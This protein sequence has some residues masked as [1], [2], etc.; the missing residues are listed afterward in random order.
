MGLLSWVFW[1][2]KVAQTTLEV[3]LLALLDSLN[4][5]LDRLIQQASKGLEALNVLANDIELV[6]ALLRVV[7][8]LAFFLFLSLMLIVSA[9]LRHRHAPYE[10]HFSAILLRLDRDLLEQTLD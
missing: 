3:G 4:V 10:V 5:L 2:L 9:W 8:C 7:D 6:V 1:V